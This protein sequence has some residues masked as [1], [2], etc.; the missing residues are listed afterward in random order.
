MTQTNSARHILII[1]DEQAVCWAL[2]RALVG[3]GHQVRVAASAEQA[4]ALL[5]RHTADVIILDVRLP[6]MDGLTA[7]PRLRQAAPD[8]AVIVITA[9]GSLPTAV[10][11][12][13]GGA[14]DY[15]AK[16]FHLDQALDA[17]GRALHRRPAGP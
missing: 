4:F 17:V 8:A 2:E 6:G 10:R 16:P 15:L 11:A 13:E 7:L 3:E 12:V 9:F 14:F 5:G 1:D